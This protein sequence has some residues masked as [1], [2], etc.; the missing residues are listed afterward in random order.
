MRAIYDMDAL[1]ES[2]FIISTGQSGNPLSPHYSDLMERWRDHRPFTIPT[3][4]TAVEA[5]RRDR[6]IL[7]PR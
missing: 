1:D 2:L 6:L 5:A 3:E 4:R 7:V